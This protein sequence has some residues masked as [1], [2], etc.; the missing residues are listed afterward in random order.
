MTSQCPV[1]D[2]TVTLSDSAEVSEIIACTDCS[3]QLVVADKKGT[4]VTLE[5]APAVEEDW[6]E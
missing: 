1:C 2:A 5:E 3:T 6:G 4:D